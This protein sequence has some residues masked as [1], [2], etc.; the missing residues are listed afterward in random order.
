MNEPYHA[1]ERVMSHIQTS[2]VPH[3][4]ESCHTALIIE[5]QLVYH[6]L[7]LGGGSNNENRGWVGGGGEWEQAIVVFPTEGAC[8]RR[9]AGP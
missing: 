7:G 4:N 3:M 8:H 9:V 2:H 6:H 5:V 1:Y